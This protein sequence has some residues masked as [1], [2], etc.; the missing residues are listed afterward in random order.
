MWVGWMGCEFGITIDVTPYISAISIPTTHERVCQRILR[1]LRTRSNSDRILSI[2]HPIHP[3]IR[4]MRKIHHPIMHNRRRPTILMHTS[5]S[6]PRQPKHIPPRFTIHNS[7]PTC[8][9]W[10]FFDMVQF[11]GSRVDQD[12]DDGIGLVIIMISHR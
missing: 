9:F 8:L 4:K 2:L 12:V 6:I 1:K 7:V 11:R 10:P 5:A 3:P